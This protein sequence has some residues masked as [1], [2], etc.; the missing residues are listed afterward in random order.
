[1]SPRQRWLT[2]TD[3]VSTPKTNDTIDITL[4]TPVYKFG[5]HGLTDFLKFCPQAQISKTLTPRDLENEV[6]TP[7]V[8]Q[9]IALP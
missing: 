9:V 6:T 5:K 3:S 7:N 4:K 2:F 1:M 8:N